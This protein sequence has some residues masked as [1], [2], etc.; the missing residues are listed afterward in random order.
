MYSDSDIE[1]IRKNLSKIE[2][3]AEKE[4]VNKYKQPNI[5][6]ISEIYEIIKKFII[7]KKR[8]VYGGYAQ[9]E[10]ILKK[11]KNDGFYKQHDLA[12]IEFYTYEPVKDLI[13]LC[14]NILKLGYKRIQGKEGVH[15][16]TYKLFIDFHNY[17]DIAYMPKNVYNKCPTININKL[18]MTHP[19]FMII[20]AY[21]VYTDLMTSNFR[22]S[23]TFNRFTKL[24]NYY[25]F[26]TDYKY[27][28][29]K[30]KLT[31]GLNG[32]ELDNIQDYIRKNIIHKSKLIIVGH[33]AFNYYVKKV[34]KVKYE[35]K[36]Y[37]Y[38]QLITDNYE[39]DV[40]KIYK[41]LKSKYG[42]KIS[43]K[44]YYPFYQFFDKRM[45]FYY[46]KQVIIKIYGNNE[47]C[48][49][50]RR[51]D[52]KLTLFGTFQTTIMYLLIDYNYAIIKNYS[53]EKSNYMSMIVKLFECRKIYL[54]DMKK[55]VIDESPFQ[56]FTLECI[57]QPVEQIRKSMLKGLEKIKK[58]KS[59]KFTYNPKPGIKGKVPNFRFEN[60]SG[61]R[62]L[63]DKSLTKLE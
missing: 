10:L 46:G 11:N 7:K 49:P 42:E 29:I 25:P 59:V 35:I 48:V 2:D 28:K 27:N 1:I 30:Y 43:T 40:K 54:K 15:E 8:I 63:N 22:L 52:K 26:D 51:S 3:E 6:E 57:G 50:F 37:P 55:T 58:G 18:R 12:D 44:E 47:R 33:Y 31:R 5:K 14:D 16:G 9:N 21:R 17:C 24:I 13:E 20:D 4:F 45:Q 34:R 23:K 62:I 36:D 19:H 32:K 41:I 61:N 39:E 38:Y 53:E 56:E 60:F